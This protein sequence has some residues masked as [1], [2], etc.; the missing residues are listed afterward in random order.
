MGARPGSGPRAH[1]PPWWTLLREGLGVS[2]EP[3][4]GYSGPLARTLPLLWPQAVLALAPLGAPARLRWGRPGG[5]LVRR[6]HQLLVSS[7]PSS[8]P[9]AWEHRGPK[10]YSLEEREDSLPGSA[11]TSGTSLVWRGALAVR[12]APGRGHPRQRGR[13]GPGHRLHRAECRQVVTTFQGNYSPGA[14]VPPP[15]PRLS[16][17]QALGAHQG[18][19]GKGLAVTEEGL[20]REGVA[21]GADSSEAE[22][23]AGTVP[24]PCP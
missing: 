17:T 10:G 19:S 2:P 18:A 22:T 15:E 8:L 7:C 14:P 16:H 21:N 20:S 3:G 24:R 1:L 4:W 11:S 9:T 13:H 12:K 6:R 23:V 5:R